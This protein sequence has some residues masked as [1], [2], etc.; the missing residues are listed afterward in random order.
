M[1]KFFLTALA[2]IIFAPAG[3]LWLVAE[4]VFLAAFFFK[5]GCSLLASMA[6]AVSATVDCDVR[7]DLFKGNIIGT[8]KYLMREEIAEQMEALRLSSVF[9]GGKR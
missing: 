1:R 2:L 4:V 3:L 5:L 8:T 6:M 9:F 7:A